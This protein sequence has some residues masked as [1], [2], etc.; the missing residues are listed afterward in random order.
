MKLQITI[1]ILILL[2][3]TMSV[4]A[5]DLINQDKIVGNIAKSIKD[6]PERWI[7]TGSMFVYCENPNKMKRLKK[8]AW[9]KYESNLFIIYNFYSTLFYAQLQ[10][11][12]AYDFDGDNLKELIQEIKLYKLRAL[13]KDVGHLLYHK[14]K[15]EKKAVIKEEQTLNED[16]LKKL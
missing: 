15:V 4:T 8:I 1:V 12:F 7:D 5:S 2:F 6:H 11:P 13:Q 14:K 3:S 10:K 16:G 9:P